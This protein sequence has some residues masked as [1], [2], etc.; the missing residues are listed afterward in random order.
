LLQNRFWALI[1]YF[2]CAGKDSRVHA[3]PCCAW[4]LNIALLLLCNLYDGFAYIPFSS[5]AGAAGHPLALPLSLYMNTC[6]AGAAVD[7]LVGDGACVL[8]R[9]ILRALFKF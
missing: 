7:S 3:L 1:A 8:S 2:L 5:W 9:T 6:I 4:A